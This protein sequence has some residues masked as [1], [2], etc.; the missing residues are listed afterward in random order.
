MKLNSADYSKIKRMTSVQLSTWISS[1][2]ESA[3]NEGYTKAVKEICDEHDAVCAVTID[4]LKENCDDD[5]V[6]KILEGVV[7]E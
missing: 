6:N 3:W 2:Y 5:T 7:K 1:F 4:W